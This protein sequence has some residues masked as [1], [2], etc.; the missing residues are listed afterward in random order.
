MHGKIEINFPNKFNQTSEFTTHCFP[1]KRKKNKINSKKASSEYKGV[2]YHMKTKKWSSQITV[3][4]EQRYLGLFEKEEEAARRYDEEAVKL[5]RS[6]NF[7]CI[8]VDNSVMCEGDGTD[9]VDEIGHQHNAYTSDMINHED[10]RQGPFDSFAMRDMKSNQL[11]LTKKHLLISNNHAFT[12]H[13]VNKKAK[14]NRNQES[15]KKGSMDSSDNNNSNDNSNNTDAHVGSNP[16]SELNTHEEMISPRISK[17]LGV[18]WLKSL[19]KWKASIVIRNE[20]VLL[21]IF[22]EEYQAALLYDEVAYNQNRPMNFNLDPKLW[23][24][25][26]NRKQSHGVVPNPTL[27]GYNIDHNQNNCSS[28]QSNN[29][30]NIQLQRGEPII[31]IYPNNFA[32]RS[33]S[34]AASVPP[35]P[36]PPPA[37]PTQKPVGVSLNVST[38]KWCVYLRVHGKHLT[39]LGSYET[40]E[41]ANHI[42][43]L[44]LQ[45]HQKKSPPDTPI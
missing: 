40:E 45:L 36:L 14:H 15:F 12:Y 23:V 18:T 3:L 35:P 33:S 37:L 25:P 10:I 7:P 9:K 29:V 39:Y 4:K 13:I 30:N 1:I 34:S 28:I 11:S 2:S 6:L 17:Y 24:H 43:N 38:G 26:K 20:K 19:N 32:S 41:E 16:P 5:G 42:Y 31:P 44:N 22:D 8:D 27:H 21:G